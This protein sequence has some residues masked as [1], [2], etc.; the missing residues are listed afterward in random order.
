MNENTHSPASQTSGPN[1]ATRPAP[2][3]PGDTVEA[4]VTTEFRSRTIA[5]MQNREEA[6][7]IDRREQDRLAKTGPV[8]G[9]D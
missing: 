1:P 8:A 4:V 7:E 5:D 2:D 9:M 3:A 6:R